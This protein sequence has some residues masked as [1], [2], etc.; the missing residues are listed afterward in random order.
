MVRRQPGSGGV[1]FK[2][3]NR[4]VVLA[5]VLFVPLYLIVR[6]T[7]GSLEKLRQLPDLV[8]RFR[9]PISWEVPEGGVR[10]ASSF[11]GEAREGHRFVLVRVRMQAR[12]NIAYPVVPR[13]FT[14]V[15]DRGS[16]Y[17]PLTQSPL[18]KARS[19]SF[20]LGRDE[21][22]DEELLFEIPLERESRTLLFERYQN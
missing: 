2:R 12:L 20:Y 21:G 8:D 7:E 10:Y 16:H 18:F 9:N 11:A 19:D 4:R 5:L 13:C 22:F 15:D 14:L 3:W 17:F 6:L 1:D